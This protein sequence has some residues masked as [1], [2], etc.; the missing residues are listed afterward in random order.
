M[1]IGLDLFFPD[2]IFGTV[3]NNIIIDRLNLCTVNYAF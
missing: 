2:N 1:Q 3:V